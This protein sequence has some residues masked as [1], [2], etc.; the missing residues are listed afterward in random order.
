[1]IKD[2]VQYFTISDAIGL[3]FCGAITLLLFI[4]SFVYFKMHKPIYIYYSLFLLFSLLYALTVLRESAA[5]D[6]LFFDFLRG[7]RRYTE[8]STLFS[9]S[10]YIF[11]SIP[12]I[13]LK[14]QS[15]RIARQLRIFA[16]A[17]L[18]YALTYYIAFAY[19]HSY[20]LIIF[21]ASR[22]LIFGLSA[23]YLI[24]LYQH[25]QSPVKNFF[26]LGSLCY[27]LGSIVASIRFSTD[28]IPN[29]SFY[30]L[31]APA[32]FQLG[33]LLQA[34]FFALAMGEKVVV[35]HNELDNEQRSIIQQL[36]LEDQ[37]TKEA[38]RRLEEEIE[39]RVKE[40]IKIR[41][42][43]EEQ[44]R[45]RVSAEHEHSL[46]KSEIQAKQAQINPHFIFNSLNA[47]KYLIL[48]NE[49]AK[50]IKYLITFSRFIRSILDQ[51][52]TES[53]SLTDEIAIVRNYIDLE[54]KRFD[55]SF[56]ICITNNLPSDMPYF[57]TP[58]FLLQPFVENAIWHGLLPSTK[59]EKRLSIVLDQTEEGVK[60]IVEDNGVGRLYKNGHVPS[61]ERGG[62]G[63]KLSLK[64][65]ELFNLNHKTQHISCHIHDL[66]DDAQRPSGTRIEIIIKTIN[67]PTPQKGVNN[68]A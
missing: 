44:E 7:N 4:V 15:P 56:N 47:I 23:Y 32:Y 16:I 45:R 49:S 63:I 19:I 11:F 66:K 30:L 57:Q 24:K 58:P 65:V 61:K 67:G 52:N 28:E 36:A 13:D 33:I 60:I 40:M 6:G 68:E 25:T 1:M 10:F 18:S 35:Q 50:A 38:N 2:T 3:V 21:I 9:F 62:L 54:K 64:R 34:L 12:L 31:A 51:A 39:A 53:I 59:H 55:D 27:F 41:E 8:S 48:Q 42:N 29:Y 46:L 22:I 20:H 17:C 26:I 14:A 5:L 43:L 37:G